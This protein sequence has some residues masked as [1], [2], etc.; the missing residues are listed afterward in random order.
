MLVQIIM[1]Q[2]VESVVQEAGVEE[3]LPEVGG[4]G[5]PEA[6]T[7]VMEQSALCA[8]MLTCGV[9]SGASEQCSGPENLSEGQ[10]LRANGLGAFPPVHCSRVEPKIVTFLHSCGGGGGHSPRPLP[11][12]P[13]VP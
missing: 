9:N 10:Y 1:V 3:G 2:T 11:R 7:T 4:V 8:G 13:P 5:M 12:S 6:G